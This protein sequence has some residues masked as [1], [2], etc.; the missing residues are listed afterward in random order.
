MPSIRRRPLGFESLEA[1]TAPA[2]GALDAAFGGGSGAVALGIAPDRPE[3]PAVTA[4]LPNNKILVAG[5]TA[6]SKHTEIVLT[7]L[8][9]D[10]TID[11]TFGTRG[12]A[13]TGHGFVQVAA[14]AVQPDGKIVVAGD[15]NGFVVERFNANGTIDT[16]FGNGGSITTTVLKTNDLAGDVKIQPDGKIVVA[17]FAETTPT[18]TT[19]TDQ[20]IL[21][22][23]TPTG[24]LDPGF[25]R[26]GVVVTPLSAGMIDFEKIVLSGRQI[27]A[28]GLT[29]NSASNVALAR[30]NANGQLDRSFGHGGYAFPNLPAVMGVAMPASGL[31]VQ[32]DGKLVAGYGFESGPGFALVRLNR[33]GRLDSSFGTNGLA[34]ADI[35]G[36]AG[37]GLGPL[38]LPGAVAVQPDGKIVEA[39]WYSVNA[40]EI[41]AIVR[42]QADG[43]LD[44]AF[45]TGGIARLDQS[46]RGLDVRFSDLAVQRDGN[47][48][49]VGSLAPQRSPSARTSHILVAR[50]L[51]SAAGT[52]GSGAIPLEPVP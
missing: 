41:G 3:L 40:P 20:G 17:G 1:R 22:R 23:Y 46:S 44:P 52:A 11:P 24:Q 21:V 8:N 33:N 9:P 16:R 25:G 50:F 4:V 31:A 30:Y 45:G 35:A 49:A 2:A 18:P 19:S 13:A 5:T 12:L 42:Y 32:R 37:S 39:G 28:A 38:E 43:S 10:G 51:A 48:L 34:S 27:V 29:T 7:R 14:M 6:G 15:S 47:L 26:H 36:G